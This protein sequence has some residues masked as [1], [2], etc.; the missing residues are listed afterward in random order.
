MCEGPVSFSVLMAFDMFCVDVDG[1]GLDDRPDCDDQIIVGLFWVW[2]E[3]WIQDLN[4][5]QIITCNSDAAPCNVE[6]LTESSQK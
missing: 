3:T 6:Q 5:F 1:E 2:T 4:S